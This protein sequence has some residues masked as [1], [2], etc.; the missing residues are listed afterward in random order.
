[1]PV[2]FP[3]GAL[4]QGS[5]P[6]VCWAAKKMNFSAFY[7]LLENKGIYVRIEF[8]CATLVE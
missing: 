3:S 7:N 6:S 5:L 2:S 1:M 4:V 8:L